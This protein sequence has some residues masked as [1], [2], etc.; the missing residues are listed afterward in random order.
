MSRLPNSD[1]ALPYAAAII[2]AALSFGMSSHWLAAVGIGAFVYYFVRLLQEAGRD[3]PIESFILVMASLQ[4]IVGPALAYSGFSDHYKYRMYV[5]VEQYMTLAVPGVLLL[6]IG[7]YAFRRENR[8][9]LVSHYIATTHQIVKRAAYLP[10][11]LIGVGIVFSVLVDRFPPA[12]AF[13][14][15]VLS[16]VKY[17]GLVYLI[18][19]DRLQYKG[20]ILIAAFGLTFL[21]SLKGAM[22]HDLLLWSAFIGMY[23]AFIFR[24]KFG[25]KLLIACLGFAFIFVLQASKDLYREKLQE[26]G[27]SDFVSK[28]VSS[29]EERLDTDPLSESN[30]LE[31]LVVRINQG[32][33]ISR[34]MQNVPDRIPHA[35]GETVAT[36]VKASLLPR[37]LFPDKPIAGGKKN[38]EKYTNFYLQSSTSMGISLLGEAYINYG[39][40]GA[41]LFMLIFGLVSSFVINRFF[42]LARTYPTI[43]L[44]FP[45][46]LLHFV[47]A[48]TELL[49]QLNFLV[50]SIVLVYLFVWANKYFLKLNI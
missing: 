5:P 6:S 40:A 41:W 15:Y 10:F 2:G 3:L 7:L 47:K 23:A 38:Y 18:F 37:L 32:W 16:N 39:V 19:S 49:V 22:F 45:L 35:E 12:L 50:K 42:K 31:R 1:A 13:P 36:A 20:G 33:I 9:A 28:F 27:R 25:H 29:V 44:W 17:I 43:W 26:G 34:I 46:I 8:F 30:N 21:S 14:A 48:E 24:P 4:W 11:Y